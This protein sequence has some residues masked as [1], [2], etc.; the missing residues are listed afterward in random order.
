MI[1][2]FNFQKFVQV[3]ENDNTRMERELAGS[4]I[5]FKL[6]D[7]KLYESVDKSKYESALKRNKEFAKEYGFMIQGDYAVLFHG[8]SKRNMK[9]IQKSGMLRNGT[10]MTSNLDVAKKYSRQATSRTA[11]SI[12]YC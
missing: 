2:I 12:K 10:W 1:K 3:Y 5:E 6:V 4:G 11:D 9:A 7:P 8:T